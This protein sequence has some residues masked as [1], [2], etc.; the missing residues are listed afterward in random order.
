MPWL[1]HLVGLATLLAVMVGGYYL[2]SHL[3]EDDPDSGYRL[4]L[5]FDNAQGLREGAGV[6]FRGVRVGEILATLCEL[7]GVDPEVVVHPE[8]YRP[9]D[10]RV[11]DADRLRLATGWTPRRALRDTLSDLFDDW[12]QQLRSAG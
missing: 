4:T 2:W 7:G 6:R 12:Q 10:C 3:G 8:R 1:R 9:A 5:L 11:G